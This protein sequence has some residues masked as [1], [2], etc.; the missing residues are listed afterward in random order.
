MKTSRF[1]KFLRPMAVAAALALTTA[2]IPAQ[3]AQAMDMSPSQCIEM[4]NAYQDA[5]EFGDLFNTFGWAR[6]AI[7][8]Y[9]RAQ[10]IAEAYDSLCP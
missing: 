3:P 8:Q 4:A 9:N 7:F 2:G 10:A 5:M 6:A 1:V